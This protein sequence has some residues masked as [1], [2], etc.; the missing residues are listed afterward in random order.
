MAPSRKSGVPVPS[1]SNTL[2]STR[3]RAPSAGCRGRRVR[4]CR[5]RRRRFGGKPRPRRRR[6][7]LAELLGAVRV[8]ELAVRGLD[9][10]EHTV[11]DLDLQRP[12]GGPP[13]QPV[14]QAPDP[15]LPI[16]GLEA[17]ELADTDPDS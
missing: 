3:T 2:P 1:Q 4:C 10:L 12:R 13:P 11:P 9:E 6:L 17:A 5:G 7:A 15:R 8:M 16:A 14:Q